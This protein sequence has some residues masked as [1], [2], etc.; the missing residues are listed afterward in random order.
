MD[1]GGHKANRL[2]E[3]NAV[4]IPARL[5]QPTDMSAPP[6]ER[7]VIEALPLSEVGFAEIEIDF[8][9]G[10]SVF[11]A[12]EPIAPKPQLL[13]EAILPQPLKEIA[14]SQP[15]KEITPSQPLKETLIPGRRAQLENDPIRERFYRMRDL[16]ASAPYA[17]NSARLFYQ[18]AVFMADFVDDYWDYAGFDMYYPC[19]QRMSYEQ[20]RTYFT[21]RTDVR[22]GRI[23][24]APVSYI[25]LYIYE[26][27]HGVGIDSPRDGMDK[28]LKVWEA[29]S[30]HYPLMDDYLPQWIKDYHIYYRLEAGFPGF[31]FK[32]DLSCF[33][34]ESFLFDPME[35]KRL[36]IWNS[37]SNYDITKSRFYQA[38]YQEQLADCLESVREGIERLFESHG[39]SATELLV[40]FGVQAT[41]AWS[42]FRHALFFDW[43]SQAER[44]IEMPGGEVYQKHGRH[45]TA[46]TIVPSK[47]LKELVGYLLKKT[48]ACLRQAVDY[49]FKIS[50]SLGLWARRF[51]GAKVSLTEL[52]RAIEQSV[53]DYYSE[54]K[55]IVVAID[56]DKLTRIRAD[57]DTTLDRLIV[58][59]GLVPSAS[60]A[61]LDGR[62]LGVDQA[63]EGIALPEAEGGKA[64]ETDRIPVAIPHLEEAKPTDRIL[65]PAPQPQ[66]IAQ[67]RL[68]TQLQAQLQV[69]SQPATQPQATFQQQAPA[70]SQVVAQPQQAQPQPQPQLATQPQ[71]WES[72]RVALT[73]V[74]CNAL[75]II[76][77]GGF[78][79]KAFADENK[80]ML[81]VLLDAINGKAI[82]CIGDI[83]IEGEGEAEGEAEAA[84][85]A[86]YR[87]QVEEIVS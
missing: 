80:V 17:G 18:Q 85:I 59:E 54:S 60:Q 35:P 63:L 76:L 22:S 46:H 36:E 47:E 41:S 53:A 25:F 28:M 67:P 68:A 40:P 65:S 62:V 73:P 57:A 69:Q 10:T 32:H 2:D 78:G 21:W 12:P 51:E 49:R 1:S 75:T 37:L 20:L 83:I 29:L 81:E 64:S 42:P 87:P 82:D 6:I 4:R 8:N 77:S 16:T 15:L 23:R 19:Y 45:W 11:E 9:A 84:I 30:G 50:A 70:L 13:G 38:G 27:L 71:P 31:V 7:E 34:P 48:E 24:T 55:R 3:Y 72:L 61:L 33:Y 79:L 52:D 66:T 5:L 56:A 58:E 43:L 14:P 26:L 44:S 39:Q 74:E 86:D